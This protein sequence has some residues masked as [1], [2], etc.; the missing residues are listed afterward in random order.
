MSTILGACLEPPST[1]DL[2]SLTLGHDQNFNGFQLP[3]LFDSCNWYKSQ[4]V[5]YLL[6]LL[7]LAIGNFK[8][9]GEDSY[10]P[11]SI[12]HRIPWE[13]MWFNPGSNWGPLAH[14]LIYYLPDHNKKEKEFLLFV[15]HQFMFDSAANINGGHISGIGRKTVSTNPISRMFLISDTHC[16]GCDGSYLFGAHSTMALLKLQLSSPYHCARQ[17]DG[18]SVTDLT[19]GYLK[20]E[21][22]LPV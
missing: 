8:V 6:R 21:Q 17:A 11:L 1:K 19:Y 2:G 3:I 22:V 4:I 10:G 12:V 5:R 15:S 18:V 14:K 13:K 9:G 7:L 20:H 16:A